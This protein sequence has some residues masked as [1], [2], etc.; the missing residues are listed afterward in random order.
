MTTIALVL[1]TAGLAGPTGLFPFAMSYSPQAGSVCDI[2]AVL[3]A[4]AGRSG[5]VRREGAHFV[6]G[7]ERIRFNGVNLTGAANFPSRDQAD[8]LASNL[9]MKGVNCVRLHYMDADYGNLMQPRERAL[10]ET[11]GVLREAELDR[12][13]YL[14]SRFKE[15]GIYVDLNLQVMRLGAQKGRT[16]TDAAL[17]EDQKVF[18]RRL[19]THTNPYTGLAWKDDPVV[20]MVELSNEDGVTPYTARKDKTKDMDLL[21]RGLRAEKDYLLKMRAFLK[22]ELGVKVPVTASCIPFVSP[23]TQA[24]GDYI[25]YHDYWCHPSPVNDQWKEME[26]PLVNVTGTDWHSLALA[27]GR[28][29]ADMPFTV[30]EY[31]HPYP[32]HYGAEGQPLLRAIAAF[33]GWDAVFTYSWANRADIEPN[34]VEYFF[35]IQAR[36]DVLA[37][38]PAAA[39]MF[40]RGDVSPCRET[41]SVPMDE[42]TYVDGFHTWNTSWCKSADV[43]QVSRCAVRFEQGL[44]HGLRLDLSGKS[45]MPSEMPRVGKRIVSDTGEIVWDRTVEGAG[46]ATVSTPNVKFF[47]G[48]AKDRTFDLDGV[49]LKIGETS[50]GWSTISLLSTD[51]KGFG[52]GGAARILLAATAYCR[53]AGARETINEKGEDGMPYM[54]TRGEDWGRGPVMCEGVPATVILPLRAGARMS[55]W[56]LDGAGRRRLRMPV[57][58]N[59][60]TIGPSAKTVWYEIDVR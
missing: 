21:R 59:A 31:G 46:Y 23:Y 43:Q 60:V 8:R 16:M 2:S 36:P 5:F 56:S 35:S 17:I 15:R 19:F 34:G 47:T 4:P 6:A 3:D 26:E 28:C 37:H 18:A 58:G 44:S 7:L 9:A 49:K 39:A 25:D 40:L 42:K 13:E 45:A 38:M 52:E 27:A 32:N 20:A 41:V 53:N 48:F 29:P 1:A 50:R 24:V 51:S 10:C 14:V 22:D 12:L 11:N 55:V 30:S 57:V 54:A 33:Q